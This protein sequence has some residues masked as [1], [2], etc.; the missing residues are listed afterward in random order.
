M[1][2]NIQS[3]PAKFVDFKD[4]ISQLAITN[5]LPDIICLQEIWNIHDVSVFCIPGYFPLECTLRT[6]S[7]GGG[8]G[9]YF[10]SNLNFK[11]L[12]D[13]SIFIEKIYESILAEV[14]LSDTDKLVVGS[15]YRPNSKLHNVTQ[16][17]QFEQFSE[18]LNN[19]LNDLSNSNS[20]LLLCG[21][22]NI[23]VLQNSTCKT[24]ASYIENLFSN[25]LLQIITKPTRVTANSA[26]CIDH[27][28]SNKIMPSYLTYIVTAKI[29]D[30]FPIFFSRDSRRTQFSPP[31]VK[32]RNFSTEN[33][34]KFKNSISSLHW[35]E[36]LACSDAQIAYSAFLNQ[37]TDLYNI[38]FPITTKK[39]N[40][41]VHAFEKWMTRGLLVSRLNKIKLG[42]LSLSSPSIENTSKYKLYRNLYNSTLRLSKK[43]FFNSELKA[44]QTNLKNTWNLLN[45]ALNKKPKS[46]LINSLKIDGS[47]ITNSTIMAENFNKYF[48]TIAEKIA[49]EI[50]PTVNLPEPPPTPQLNVGENVPLFNMSKTPVSDIE[51]SNALKLLQDKKSQDMDGFSMF[52]IKQIA[53]QISTPLKHVLSL[54]IETGEI[55]SQMKI[56]KVVPIHK[57]GDS[58]DMNNYRPISLLSTFSKI[59]EKIVACRL[60]NFLD[61]NKILTKTQFGFRPGHSTV[62][63][64]THLLNFV[65]EA[66][67]AKKHA[68]LIFC[69]LRKAF[70]TCNFDILLKKLYKI[71][72]RGLELQ[73]FENYLK[74]RQ[75]FVYLNGV[76]SSLLEILN[77]V[78]Q[79]S[80]LGPLLFLL[81]INDISVHTNLL[82]V[83]FADDTALGASGENLQDLNTEINN[84]FHKICTYF[85]KN[86]LSLHPDKTKFIV[87]SN[88]VEATNSDFKIFISESNLNFSDPLANRTEISRVKKED[89]VPAIKYLGVYFDPNLNF[90]FHTQMLCKKI[91]KSIYAIRTVKNI[92]PE[93]ALCSLYFALLHSHLVYA[94]QIWSSG[95]GSNMESMFK[96]QKKAIRI[97]SNASYN[98]HTE[99]LFKSLEILPLN[100]LA[101]FSK[102]QFMQHFK[103]KYLPQAL[104]NTWQSNQERRFEDDP[105]QLR[106]DNELHIPLARTDQLSRFPLFHL[107]K[108]W[109]A[110][111]EELKIIRHK[112]T[113]STK[114]KKHLLSQLSTTITCSRLFCPSCS[115]INN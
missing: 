57:S 10:K 60:S 28:L 98:A 53:D 37:L 64:M 15:V 111:P 65:T 89:K 91:S 108:L 62:H 16:T 47:D 70:D 42:N 5:S 115:K 69:D 33:I 38:H 49:N 96:L 80:I 31:S 68:V 97:I 44:N 18:L 17:Q 36:V 100:L 4:F 112:Q 11:I 63:A 110:L 34:K 71:G 74:N 41:N 92:L 93:S 32:S 107:P 90:K 77:G 102:T 43:N 87:F 3:L 6:Q 114:L 54:S 55:P 104:S 12:K 99:P 23:D 39:F 26:T 109:N 51:I 35:G 48:T 56:A 105:R 45:L 20:E 106:N 76:A 19:T 1:S 58:A 50:P 113:F 8:V 22:F 88:N 84:E 40:K 94:V 83:L 81:Y 46:N 30:H 24:A 9:F 14:W 29:S 86:K 82:S 27:I 7:Q 72:I 78:P 59:L 21:D 67:N 75:Q 66:L 25:G 13:K 73:W 103:Q 79:G 95:S 52:F 2:L 101:E 85:R 61:E